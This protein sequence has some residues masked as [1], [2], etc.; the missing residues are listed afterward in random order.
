MKKVFVNSMVLFS[1]LFVAAGLG[2]I[3]LR[4]FWNP[5]PECVDSKTM[6]GMAL[7]GWPD[8][9]QFVPGT[10]TVAVS[11]TAEFAVHYAINSLCMRDRE[12]ARNRTAGTRR[13]VFIGDSFTEG[14]GV[15]Q[16]KVY[17]A[18]I[19]KLSRGSLEC[20]NAG[21]R[22]ICPSFA[23]F[24]LQRL[25]ESGLEFDEVVYQ[26]FDNDFQD[27]GIH[28]DQFKLQLDP[29]ECIIR[30]PFNQANRLFYFFGPAAWPLSQLRL[31][32]LV[33]AACIRLPSSPAEKRTY[34]APLAQKILDVYRADGVAG[35]TVST[36]PA[37]QAEITFPLMSKKTLSESKRDALWRLLKNDNHKLDSGA[38]G[39]QTLITKPA[40]YPQE[41]QRSLRYLD[42]LAQLCGSRAIPLRLV[43][44][45]CMPLISLQNEYYF[46]KWCADRGVP[47]LSLREQLRSISMQSENAIFFPVDGHLSEEGHAVIAH[48]IYQ[49]LTSP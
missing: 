42:C 46:G 31:S 30:S 35:V 7:P 44:Q 23:F 6:G 1:A 34:P 16:H 39:P 28:T 20:L 27:D 8:F 3:L 13:L 22:G 10:G 12:H 37:G 15:A 49:W 2:E 24:R 14:Y 45:P 21:M 36:L 5:L 17:P 43:Y 4:V 47:F 41:V 48:I 19:E 33:A 29:R 26:V 25:L 40:D 9:W 11:P 38:P 32:W 18:R